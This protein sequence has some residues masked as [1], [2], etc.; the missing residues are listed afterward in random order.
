VVAPFLV[1]FGLSNL[2][3]IHVDQLH[4]WEIYELTMELTT[5]SGVVYSVA[6]EF[7][8]SYAIVNLPAKVAVIHGEIDQ[9]EVQFR[10]VD[11][12]HRHWF[13]NTEFKRAAEILAGKYSPSNWGSMRKDADVLF[14][15]A[16]S[17]AKTQ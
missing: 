6:A 8:F 14:A 5:E 3:L 11:D 2:R 13:L 12:E 16:T 15:A 10:S 9:T 1:M 4:L 17:F 7:R